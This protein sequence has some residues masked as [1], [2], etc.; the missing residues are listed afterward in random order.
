MDFEQ[1]QK[2]MSAYNEASGGALVNPAPLA[3]APVDNYTSILTNPQLQ[4]LRGK[5]R[6][7]LIRKRYKALRLGKV[8]HTSEVKCMEGPNRGKPGPCPKARQAKPTVRQHART[9]EAAVEEASQNLERAFAESPEHKEPEPKEPE[10]VKQAR[11]SWEGVKKVGIAVGVTVAVV[12]AGYALHKMD[13]ATRKKLLLAIWNQLKGV[14]KA[15]AE[16]AEETAKGSAAM[17]IVGAVARR[18][19]MELAVQPDS[20]TSDRI[21][22]E[23]VDE[24]GRGDEKYDNAFHD[25]VQNGEKANPESIKHLAEFRRRV[26]KEIADGTIDDKTLAGAIN[27][28][29]VTIDTEQFRSFIKTPRPRRSETYAENLRQPKMARLK[30]LGY[31]DPVARKIFHRRIIKSIV[32]NPDFYF[33]NKDHYLRLIDRTQPMTERDTEFVDQFAVSVAA[34]AR[35]GEVSARIISDALVNADADGYGTMSYQEFLNDLDPN[36][37]SI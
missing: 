29:D 9:Q 12:G 2:A 10:R 28:V 31:F 34:A 33:P 14:G 6:I 13:P 1:L 25:V 18:L 30:H 7:A 8:I 26:V 22:Q 24:R 36:A 37:K 23:L 11:V 35:R 27:R 17:A 15:T 3:H 21:V 20:G 19:S 32:S 16:H 5:K 4:S